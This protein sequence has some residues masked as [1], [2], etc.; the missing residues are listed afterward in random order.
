M[1]N[2]LITTLHGFDSDDWL[3][4]WSD[5]GVTMNGEGGN[6][7]LNG[8]SGDDILEGDT[9]NDFLYGNS[10]NDT[11]IFSKGSGNDTIEDWNG[12]SLVKFTDIN[13]DE[14]SISKMNDSTL[15]LT[16]DSTGDTLTVNDTSGIKVA[17]P[18]NLLTEQLT[19]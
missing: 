3:S 13:I 7:T 10:G 5:N 1:I 14:I 18:L 11:Y 19:A 4:A 16:I 6:D 15:V 12:S 9:G 17:I 8:G 2:D